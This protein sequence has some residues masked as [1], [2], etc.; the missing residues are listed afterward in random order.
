MNA[1]VNKPA[2]LLN[3]LKFHDC[4]PQDVRAKYAGMEYKTL[5]TFSDLNGNIPYR[6]H[7]RG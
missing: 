5:G 2:S 1:T 7:Q 3:Y 4:C 6:F